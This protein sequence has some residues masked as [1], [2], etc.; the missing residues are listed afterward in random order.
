MAKEYVNNA[1]DILPEYE[2][3]LSIHDTQCLVDVAMPEF[4]RLVINKTHPI[5]GVVG[6]SGLDGPFWD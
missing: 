2:L 5:A 4:L 1:D 6:G 3:F